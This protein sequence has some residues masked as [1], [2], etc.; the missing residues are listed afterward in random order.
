MNEIDMR[1][2]DWA[3]LFD[4]AEPGPEADQALDAWLAEDVRH[5]GAFAR[6]QAMLVAYG[7][8]MVGDADAPISNHRKIAT[9]DR[10]RL[11]WGSGMAA[12][13]AALS[14]GG[15]W[16]ASAETAYATS[17]GER[18]TIALKGGNEVTLN[19]STQIRVR[20]GDACR[21]RF[22]DGEILIQSTGRPV[23]VSCGA[24][25]VSGAD[26]QFSIRRQNAETVMT[27]VRGAVT[28]DGLQAPV[29]AGGRIDLSLETPVLLSPLGSDELERGLS[30]RTGRLAFEG[31]TLRDA[32]AEFGRYS[33]T[34]IVLA[35]AATGDR[36]ITGL[37]AADD[38]AGFARAVAI[39]S[40]L[41]AE[42]RE[43]RI[44]LSGPG[45]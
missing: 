24:A 27:V 29:R 10:R 43:G 32:A 40:G 25:V 38:P 9:P 1:A 5:V 14:V 22:L 39:T 4:G 34:P 7:D 36:R 21:L 41:R 17:I 11:L 26:A 44:Y 3:A 20:D 42:A 23:K 16:L 18:R 28:V 2:A 30:W 33:A 13:L 15:V 8:S 31:E 35:D 37:F 12:G 45:D 19:T 6:A